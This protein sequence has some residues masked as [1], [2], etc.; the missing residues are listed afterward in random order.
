MY[1]SGFLENMIN[2][3]K[4][5]EDMDSYWEAAVDILLNSDEIIK[6]LL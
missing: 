2:S 5:R 3:S 4:G 6:G 1:E